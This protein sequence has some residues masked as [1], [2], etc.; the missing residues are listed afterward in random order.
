MPPFVCI[1]ACLWV[2]VTVCGLS[3]SFISKKRWPKACLI[4]RNE[5]FFTCYLA[6]LPTYLTPFPLSPNPCVF[7]YVSSWNAAIFFSWKNTATLRYLSLYF[8]GFWYFDLYK[9][10]ILNMCIFQIGETK[11]FLKTIKCDSKN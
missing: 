11:L 2:C 3:I 9:N 10:I 1:Y 4:K 8:L 7:S 6:T 5:S